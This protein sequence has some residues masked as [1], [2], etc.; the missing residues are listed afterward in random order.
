MTDMISFCMLVFRNRVTYD[1]FLY[2]YSEAGTFIQEKY[3]CF[4]YSP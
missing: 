1:L 4:D 2:S 3:T